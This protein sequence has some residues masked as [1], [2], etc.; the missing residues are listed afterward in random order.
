[1]NGLLSSSIKA[2]LPRKG[3][4][5]ANVMTLAGGSTLSHLILIAASPILTRLY[6]PADFGLWALFISLTNIMGGIAAWRYEFAIMLAQEDGDAANILGLCLL[7]LA[8]MCGLFYSM[9]ALFGR[10]IAH[11]LKSPEISI[12]LWLA[13][14]TILLTG[15][16]NSLNYWSTRKK[17]F[18]SVA[19]SKV[20][21]SMGIAGTQISAGAIHSPVPGGLI[22]GQVLGQAV[23]TGILAR[24]VWKADGRAICAALSTTGIIDQARRHHKFPLL[25]MWST[26]AN[27]LAR[28]VPVWFIALS[29]GT[30]DTGFFS[31]AYR[32]IFLPI[33]LIAQAV[34]QVFYQRATELKN[35]TGD[36]Y[37]FAK[38]LT[39]SLILIPAI[40]FIALMLW[41]PELFALVFGGNW[42]TAGRYAAILCPLAWASFV[43][44]P[45]TMINAVYEYQE[46]H[47][48]WQLGLLSIASIV[49]YATI[50]YQMPLEQIL[51]YYSSIVVLWYLVNLFILLRISQGEPLF[52]RRRRTKA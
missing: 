39:L 44:G 9:V 22:A 34:S 15:L 13:P 19:V 52:Y 29:F 11:L 3:N 2:I 31:L 45:L 37:S 35:L 14:L 6:S 24:Q 12:W 21:A 26:L 33:T 25:F 32:T 47:L 23:G 17:K 51:Y 48:F 49:F 8:L 16:F 20:S 28:Q 4:F 40:P 18:Q 41:G 50:Q 1:M 38:R 27:N 43:V 10:T 36:S 7:I 46:M 30:Q 5:T 42:V